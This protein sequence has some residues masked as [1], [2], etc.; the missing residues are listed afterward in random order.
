MRIL[1]I[2]PENRFIRAF[3]QGQFNN[4]VQ[5]TMPYL[6]G[7]VQPPHQVAIID[8]YNQAICFDTPADL[9]GITCNTPNAGHV[10]GLAD[11]FRRQGRM[12]V[13]GGPHATLLPEEA[14]VHADAVVV[15]EAERTWPAVIED[16]AK[17]FLQPYYRDPEPPSLDGLPNARRDLI[18]RRGVFGETIVATRGCPHK[19]AYCNL[20]QIYD[21]TP[22]FRPIE[23]L[24][25]EI[26]TF[27]S[28]YFAFWD[29]QLFMDPGYSLRLFERL[30]NA[31]K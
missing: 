3:R 5:L 19:C 16:A 1:L 2:T 24:V 27:R 9:V 23:E 7:F 20:R 25:G 30:A 4:F 11:S 12:V 6:A 26:Q 17:G 29:D 22:R 28:P 31:G 21:P 18:Y 10:Y 8:E 13:L 14:K 15:G